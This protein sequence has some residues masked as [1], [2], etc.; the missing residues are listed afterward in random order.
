MTKILGLVMSVIAS[1]ALASEPSDRTPGAS[2]SPMRALLARDQ[3]VKT[4]LDSM[5]S[6]SLSADVRQQIKDHINATFDFTELSK[7]SLGSHWDERS[8]PEKEHFISVFGGIIQ[9]QNFEGFL[10]YDRESQIDYQNEQI[11]STKATVKALVPLKAEQVEIT[12]HLHS[13]DG[14]WKAYDLLID[15]SSTAAGHRRRHVR[16]IRKYSYARLVE[17]LQKQLSRL[18]GNSN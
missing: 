17:Q 13:V 10:R 15:G 9:E 2:A 8:A 7:L 18:T 3:S 6:D 14:E 12:Y 5:G 16:Y 4:I 11:D 1:T